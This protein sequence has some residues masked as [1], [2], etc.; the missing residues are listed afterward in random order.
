MWVQ[1]IVFIMILSG[2]YEVKVPGTSESMKTA[3]LINNIYLGISF[4][5]KTPSFQNIQTP[6]KQ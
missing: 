5:E 6:R 3:L 4:S 1:S 2:A